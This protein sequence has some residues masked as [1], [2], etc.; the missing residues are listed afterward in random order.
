MVLPT[1][2]KQ[3]SAT[4]PQEFSKRNGEPSRQHISC[5]TPFSDFFSCFSVVTCGPHCDAVPRL[6]WLNCLDKETGESRRIEAGPHHREWKSG[7]QSE[8][9]KRAAIRDFL[10]FAVCVF[11]I[12]FKIRT[13]AQH[14]SRKRRIALFATRGNPQESD[15]SWRDLLNLLASGQDGAGAAR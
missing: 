8:I 15:P 13:A 6:H 7:W 10:S 2:S 9:A 5:K 11:S 1:T 3:H 12:A 4:A 14:K